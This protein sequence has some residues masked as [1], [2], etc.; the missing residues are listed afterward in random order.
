MDTTTDKNKQQESKCSSI[1]NWV[2]IVIGLLFCAAGLFSWFGE[3]D[4]MNNAIIESGTTQSCVAFIEEYPES[5]THLQGLAD[6]LTAAIEA[7]TTSP[8]ALANI[9]NDKLSC[10][11]ESGVDVSAVVNAIVL[12]INTA[13]QVSE[14]EAQYIEKVKRIVQGINASIK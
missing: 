4:T 7:R 14:T 6:A 1:K 10:L 11:S 13:H 3:D 2:V 9:I 5:K 8:D 12:N